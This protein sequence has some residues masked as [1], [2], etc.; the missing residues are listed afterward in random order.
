MVLWL[1]SGFM[2]MAPHGATGEWPVDSQPGSLVLWLSSCHVFT[3]VS[4]LRLR[5]SWTPSCGL[6]PWPQGNAWLPKAPK[7][8]PE[9]TDT[10]LTSH[11]LFA[12]VSF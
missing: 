4:A 6:W 3:V 9:P 12:H 1:S 8:D 7:L 2:E 10:R 11:R 5:A